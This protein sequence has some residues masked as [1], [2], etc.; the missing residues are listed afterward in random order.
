MKEFF[1]S[2]VSPE[3]NS[4]CW[5]WTGAQR[6]GYGYMKVNGKNK[7]A[8]HVAWELFV[9]PIPKR[10]DYFG[11]CVLHKCDN[12]PCV[13]P[14]HLCLGSHQD[15][16]RDRSQKGHDFG[17]AT[18]V[19][20]GNFNAKLS[21]KDVLEIKKLLVKHTQAHVAREYG[22]SS[23]HIHRIKT[24]KRWGHVSIGGR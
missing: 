13:N 7:Q 9:G 14:D 20:A 3:P 1:L 11:T 4:G 18:Q 8:T 6:K 2:R 10:D 15:N 21:E 5:L 12:P 17:G 22:I 23:A 19:G 24:G 16:M